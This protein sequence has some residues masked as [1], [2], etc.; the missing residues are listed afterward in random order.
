MLQKQTQSW[1]NP[2]HTANAVYALLVSGQSR[3]DVKDSSALRLDGELLGKGDEHRMYADVK[4]E[5]E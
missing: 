2:Y 1:D 4:C 3:F 5:K